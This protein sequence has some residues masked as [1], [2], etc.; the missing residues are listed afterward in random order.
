MTKFKKKN[1]KYSFL[2]PFFPNFAQKSSP[3][4]FSIYSPLGSCKKDDK[5]NKPILRI[6]LN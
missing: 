4:L 5:T 6:T 2:G 1:A 3:Q